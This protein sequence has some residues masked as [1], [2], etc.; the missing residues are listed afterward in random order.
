MTARRPPAVDPTARSRTG[1]RRPRVLV[2]RLDSM[3]DVLLAGPAVRALSAHA[4]VDVLCS[5]IGRPAA[6][7]LPGVRRVLRFDAPWVLRDAPAVEAETTDQLVATIRSGGYAAAA[8]LTSSHQS[9]LPLALLLRLAGVARIAGVSVD[10]AGRLL[11]HRIP[12]D[13]DVHEV[14]RALIVAEAL[15]AGRPH[16]VALAVTVEAP[17]VVDDRIVVHPGSAAPARTLAPSRWR[18]V[19]AALVADGWS[20]VVTGSPGEA[21][22]CRFVAGAARRDDPQ[23]RPVTVA[24]GSA[25]PELARLLGSAA[26]VVSGNTGP[27][28]LAAAMRRP[29]A[30]V[31]APTVPAQRW[32]P[33]MV[34]HRVLGDQTVACA[35]CRAVDCPLEI[36]RCLALVDAGAVVDAVSQLAHEI[37]PG[38]PLMEVMR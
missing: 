9:P 19:V 18:A 6:A 11:D 36:Q 4:D 38:R 35:G 23:E 1:S 8:V 31:F 22:L 28:H 5:G 13:P 32:A 3:G 27:M 24:T 2:A 25:L 21:E 15:G 20:V 12:G 33:W 7:I 17:P 26:V 34:P 14:E 29:V 16:D 30:A 10:H 37:I